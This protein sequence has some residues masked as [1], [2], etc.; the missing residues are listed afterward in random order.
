MDRQA[1]SGKKVKASIPFVRIGTSK[2][3]DSIVTY[4]YRE[5]TGREQSQ[6][7]YSKGRYESPGGSCLGEQGSLRLIE[8]I[9]TKI[10]QRIRKESN[11]Y[12]E[13]RRFGI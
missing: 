8:T 1:I 5:Y 2:M 9:M 3:R 6:E 4:C 12:H 11:R 13:H 7:T 10:V